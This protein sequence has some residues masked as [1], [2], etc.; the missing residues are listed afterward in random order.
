MIRPS[1]EVIGELTSSN[2]VGILATEGTVKSESYVIELAKFSPH[3]KVIQH[4]CPMWVPLIENHQHESLAGKMFIEDDVKNLLSKDP[5]ID[6][7]VLG[8][9]H[10]PIVKEYIESI[11]PTNV[12]VVSQ[13]SIVAEKLSLY[14]DNHP[15]IE[16]KCAKSGQVTFL[17]TENAED[18]DRKAALFYPEGISSKHI[19]LS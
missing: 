10:Y 13:G 3:T 18:F 15:E 9:T 16:E 7:I 17:T 12:Q 1:T 2:H 19:K 14:L 4:A 8:C 5:L 6:M 11:V